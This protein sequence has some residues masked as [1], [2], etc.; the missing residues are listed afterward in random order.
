MISHIE[1]AAPELSILR[2]KP[3]AP[4]RHSF[5]WLNRLLPLLF[6]ILGGSS[7]S[8][9]LATQEPPSLKIVAL[10]TSLTSRGG[11]PEM[12]EKEL[13]ACLQETVTV[14]TVALAG[15][16]TDWALGQIDRVTGEKPDIVLVEFYANDAAVN[17]WM[18]VS[19][20]R[21]NISAILD[22]LHAGAP[23]ARIVVMAMNP[24]SGLRGWMRP[25]LSSYIDAHREEAESRGMGFV[26][27]RPAWNALS[28]TDRDRA[29]PDGLHPRPEKAGEVMTPILV[30]HLA[31]NGCKPG[32]TTP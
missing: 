19:A 28:D 21:S 15:S 13:S 26:D 11:W 6:F 16:T 1:N 27:F 12:L 24:I 8:A 7:S 9:G 30:R 20:S 23:Q 10:G 5:N 17:R 14:K 25:F 2:E 22:G 4:A 3:P 29:I 18:S 31:E 32:K